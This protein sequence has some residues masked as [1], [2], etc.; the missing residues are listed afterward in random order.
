MNPLSRTVKSRTLRVPLFIRFFFPPPSP[1]LYSPL[2]LNDNV[3]RLIHSF[4]TIGDI[5]EGM[6]F[7]F[8]VIL[9]KRKQLIVRGNDAT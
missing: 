9:F 7:F 1:L 2:I 6:F 3:Y 5:S 8:F 4:G